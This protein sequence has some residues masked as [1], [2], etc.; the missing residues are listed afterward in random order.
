MGHLAKRERID[1]ARAK[2]ERGRALPPPGAQAWKKHPARARLLELYAEVD[3]LLAPYTCDAS[4]ECCRFGITGREPYPTAV[5]RAEIQRA[6]AALGGERAIARRVVLPKVNEERPCPLLSD[7][8]R[9]RVYASRPFGCRTFF[10]DRVAGPGKL[11]R[12]EIQRISRDMATLSAATFPGD[13]H[14]R[15]LTH[16][17]RNP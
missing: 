13:P 8:G 17:L 6:I 3:A 11:P 16:A 1:P 10:C 14:A 15:P 4:T 2:T 9:C 5:E 7:G 12:D